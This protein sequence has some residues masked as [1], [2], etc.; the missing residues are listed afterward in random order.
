[1]ERAGCLAVRW[2]DKRYNYDYKHQHYIRFFA[3]MV[4]AGISVAVSPPFES[5]DCRRS[6]LRPGPPVEVLQMRLHGCAG[7]GAS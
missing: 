2:K 7:A 4:L 3:G 6:N 5:Y 1:M